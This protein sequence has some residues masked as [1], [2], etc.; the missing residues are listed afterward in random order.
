MEDKIPRSTEDMQEKNKR[1]ETVTQRGG[2]VLC[3]RGH[4]DMQKRKGGSKTAGERKTDCAVSER[5]LRC[6]RKQSCGG[7]VHGIL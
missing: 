5:L 4:S 1:R 2:P 6:P 3:H 7:N